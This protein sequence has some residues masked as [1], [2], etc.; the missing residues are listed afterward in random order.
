M[1]SRPLIKIC[2]CTTIK[3]TREVAH[4]GIDMIGFVCHPESKRHVAEDRLGVLT[5]VCRDYNIKSVLVLVNQDKDEIISIAN[6][7][8]PDFLQLHGAIAQ[9]AYPFLKAYRCLIP[10][11]MTLSKSELRPDDFI[12][13][14]A[15]TP[16][17]GN[18]DHFNTLQIDNNASSFIAGGIT[19]N[20]VASLLAQF[21]PVGVDV[22]T[23]VEVLPGIKSISKIKSLI[24]AI[25]VAHATG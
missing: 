5:Q 3:N 2:G 13:Y 18:A 15:P 19:P 11:N 14:D 22:S 10:A 25:E 1:T 8:Q 24:N 16:G 21:K 6:K 17:S 20:N 4:A 12:L 9:S 7:I 23:G